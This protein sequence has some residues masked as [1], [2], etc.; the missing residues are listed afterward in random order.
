MIE[1]SANLHPRALMLS[2]YSGSRQQKWDNVKFK[3]IKFLAG[4]K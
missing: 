4:E 2:G 1:E 3:I